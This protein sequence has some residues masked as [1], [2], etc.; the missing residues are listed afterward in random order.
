MKGYK[1]KKILMIGSS[2]SALPFLERLKK[3]GYHVSVCGNKKDDPCHQYADQSFFVD[4]GDPTNI[5]EIMKNNTFDFIMPS[6]NDYSYVTGAEV[7]AQ[8]PHFKGFDSVETTQIL[9]NKMAF[10]TFTTE[11]NIKV[12]KVYAPEDEASLSP[13]VDQP[14]AVKPQNSFSGRGIT[15]VTS[16]D[17]IAP[18]IKAAT[19]ASRTNDYLIEEFVAGELYAHSA[20]IQDQ[21]IFFETFV[22]EFCSVYPYQVDT[23]CYPS[24][25]PQ[26]VQKRVH[27]EIQKMIK[28]LRLTD[29]LLHTQFISDGDDFWIIECTRRCP[30]DLFPK[31]I[32]CATGVDFHDLFLQKFIGEVYTTP[33]VQESVKRVARHVISVQKDQPFTHYTLPP[34][35]M[36]YPLKLSGE[37]FK[38]AP[39]DK[40]GIALI[41][42]DNEKE[43][44]EQTPCLSKQIIVS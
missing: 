7:V 21:E 19:E 36:L 3:R 33:A 12:P 26:A 39:Y 16:T 29:G 25:L 28:A 2:H 22:D 1:M 9:H 44:L 27:D 24:H 11:H 13:S 5:L 40:A 23:S 8:Y 37:H 18:A 35:S 43:F 17:Q 32:H 10:R 15:K 6:S 30:G 14:V 34:N 31:I 38:A 4:Y 42:F 41:T 20:F